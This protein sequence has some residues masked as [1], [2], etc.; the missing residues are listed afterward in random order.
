MEFI[1]ES[2]IVLMLDLQSLASIDC[3]SLKNGLLAIG[4]SGGGDPRRPV[5]ESLNLLS[6]IG[7]KHGVPCSESAWRFVVGVT[8]TEVGVS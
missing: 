8:I 1:K 3:K 5:K 7:L 2:G 6:H 4:L